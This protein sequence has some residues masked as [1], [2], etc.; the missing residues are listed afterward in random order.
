[1]RPP[2]ASFDEILYADDTILASANTRAMNKML[3]DLEEGAALYGLQLNRSKCVC[4]NMYCNADIKFKDGTPLK[5]V[6]EAV[7]LGV[8]LNDEMNGI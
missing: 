1:M 5:K 4:I 8:N 2:G 3:R 7:Y 6:E